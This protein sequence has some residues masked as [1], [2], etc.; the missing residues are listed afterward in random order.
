[1][2]QQTLSHFKKNGRR[3]RI[4][5]DIAGLSFA[6]VVEKDGWEATVEMNQSVFAPPQ[7]REICLVRVEPQARLPKRRI[8]RI[9]KVEFGIAVVAPIVRRLATQEWGKAAAIHRIGNVEPEK[10]ED[11]WRDIDRF[12]R[13][14]DFPTKARL[15]RRIADDERRVIGRVIIVHLAPGMMIAQHLAVIGHDDDKR[16]VKLAGFFEER[17]DPPEVLVDLTRQ[18]QIDRAKLCDCL[19]RIFQTRQSDNLIFRPLLFQKRT[20]EWVGRGLGGTVPH[21]AMGGSRDRTL[22]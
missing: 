1:M 17:D 12:R 5:S 9:A 2:V 13:R 22:C 15:Q 19:G 8:N 4:I 11:R 3:R 18:R 16:I 21:G 6:F 7:N 20:I 10:T 14:V